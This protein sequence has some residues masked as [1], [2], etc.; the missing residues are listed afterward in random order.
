LV[1]TSDSK[2]RPTWHSRQMNKWMGK[3]E[4]N[5]GRKMEILWKK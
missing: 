1:H 4:C 2:E 3:W 5:V